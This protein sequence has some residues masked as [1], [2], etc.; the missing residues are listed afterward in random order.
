VATTF[1]KYPFFSRSQ[2]NAAYYIGAGLLAVARRSSGS[3]D[4]VCKCR[5]YKTAYEKDERN[6][7]QQEEHKL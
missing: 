1:T 6:D 7:Y 5:S 2:G 3:S 4:A